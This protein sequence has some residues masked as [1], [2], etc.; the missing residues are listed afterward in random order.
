MS[1]SCF[2]PIYSVLVAFSFNRREPVVV[3]MLIVVNDCLDTHSV[4][5]LFAVPLNEKVGGF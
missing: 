4:S 5:S 2:D 3:V 1:D